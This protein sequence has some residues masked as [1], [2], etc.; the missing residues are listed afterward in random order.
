MNTKLVDS[1]V[2]AIDNL[3]P[4]EQVLIRDRLGHASPEV[5]LLQKIRQGIPSALQS[6][7]DEMRRRLQ[8]DRLLPEEHSDFLE[9]T[10]QIEQADGDRLADLVAL[11][12]LRQVSLP[13]LM[14]QLNLPAPPVYV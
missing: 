14:Q 11:A 4:E 1:I 12:Q 7:Y 8:A 6:R 9:L 2:Q 13:E 3:S 5:E 10:A